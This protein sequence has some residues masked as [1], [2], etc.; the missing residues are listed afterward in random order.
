MARKYHS[1]QKTT[2]P[3]GLKEYRRLQQRD[4][5]KRRKV[6]DRLY[7]LLFGDVWDYV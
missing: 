7:R 1:E 5:R 4:I 6:E 2:T 3:E